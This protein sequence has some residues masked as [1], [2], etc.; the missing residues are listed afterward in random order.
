M[1]ADAVHACCLLLPWGKTIV[2]VCTVAMQVLCNS[3]GGCL[4]ASLAKACS[5]S[6]SP[7]AVHLGRFAN[8][9]FLGHYAACCADT[10]A[11]E[12]GI[13]SQQWPR[14]ISNGRRVPPGTNGGVTL[15]GSCWALGASAFI[16]AAWAV[17]SGMTGTP[18]ALTES[19]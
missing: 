5:Y 2:V 18:I 9:A 16:G 7:A 14:L 13:L 4:A 1:H 3:L 12:G 19:M 17:V 6:L 11:S 10:W 8:G 15:L